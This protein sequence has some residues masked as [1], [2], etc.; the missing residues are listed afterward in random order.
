[1]T[2]PA[3]W[4]SSPPPPERANAASIL[5]GNKQIRFAC[6][7]EKGAYYIRLLCPRRPSIRVPIE[8]IPAYWYV[9]IFYTCPTGA[10]IQKLS[11]D[12]CLNGLRV[13]NSTTGSRR[14]G[15]GIWTSPA[16]IAPQSIDLNSSRVKRKIVT[17]LACGLAHQQRIFLS[18]LDDTLKSRRAEPIKPRSDEGNLLKEQIVPA[19]SLTRCVKIFYS[20]A[21]ASTDRP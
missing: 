1:M 15:P 7:D 21:E 3:G 14:P 16:E 17:R 2:K 20:H 5:G 8:T 4:K 9:S 12:S 6:L 19:C 10:S 13:P 11:G 18:R